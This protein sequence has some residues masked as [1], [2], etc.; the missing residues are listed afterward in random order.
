MSEWKYISFA[1][2]VEINPAIK[3]KTGEEYS[4]VEMK[5]LDATKKFVSPSAK[6]KLT[7][8]SRF[9]NGNTLFARI[10]PCLENGKICQVKNLENG[11]GFGSTEFLVLR[12]KE[13]VSDT[14]F[15]YYLSRW[16]DVRSFAVQNMIGTSGRQRVGKDA[17]INLVLEF[18]DLK[19]QQRI[20]SIL[21]SLDDAIE[22]NQQINKTLDEMAKAIFKEWFVDFNFP[23]TTGKF[24]ETEIGKIPVGWKVGKLGDV[25]EVNKNTLNKKTDLLDWIDYI[26]ISEV[27]KGLI[28]KVTRY[29]LGEEPSRAKRKLKHGDTV[30]STVRPDR[31]SYFLAIEPK[32][33][34]IASTGFAVFSPLKVPYSYLHLFLTDEVSFKYYGQ[35]ANGGAYPAINPNT[36]ME[37]NLIIPGNE[38]LSDF[39]KIVEPFFIQIQQNIEENQSLMNLRDTLLPKLMKGEI[40]IREKE[41][42]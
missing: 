27:S 10:T 9:Q 8:G 7:G 17:F 14:E 15:V 38:T 18:P 34:D 20:A 4:F 21:T 32:K 36:I 40:E 30:L 42:V 33:T 2:F 24:Q 1:D 12:G 19:T 11:I 13:K 41:T 29:N 22:L 16:N 39:H 28:G 3:L 25:C 31:G 5:D 37:M 6:R 35:V 26:E 23:N